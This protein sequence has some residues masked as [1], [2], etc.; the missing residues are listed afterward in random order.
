MTIRHILF[1]FALLCAP[2]AFASPVEVTG[3]AAAA[4][5][6]IAGVVLVGTAVLAI[7]VSLWAVSAVRSSLGFGAASSG[8][9]SS[10]LADLEARLA[11]EDVA[12]GVEW[13]DVGTG[14]SNLDYEREA[15]V[16]NYVPASEYAGPFDHIVLP[17]EEAM[18]AWEAGPPAPFDHQ[19]V[20]TFSASHTAA[21]KAGLTGAAVDKSAWGTEEYL[22]YDTGLDEAHDKGLR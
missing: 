22:A 19:D 18:A 12:N 8:R 3:A 21:Y 15:L 11:A 20:S 14:K 13:R 10:Y 9:G 2:V 5:N 4:F 7:Y 17:S 6:V 16:P 1:V